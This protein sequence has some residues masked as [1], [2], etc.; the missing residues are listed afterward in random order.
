MQ[1]TE[2]QESEEIAAKISSLNLFYCYDADAQ[3]PYEW[4]KSWNSDENKNPQGIKIELEFNTEEK[5][6]F[7]KYIFI[8]TGEKGKAEE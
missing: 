2:E 1:E 6:V 7:T 3:P 5:L 8:P 4:K